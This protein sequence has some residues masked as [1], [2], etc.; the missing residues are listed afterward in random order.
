M[1][2][3]NEFLQEVG[4]IN[5]FGHS[6]KTP[7]EYHVIH[8]IFE[9]YD[10]WNEQMLITWEPHICSLENIAI[11][12]L[13]DEQI[14]FIF[15][16]ISSE[17]ADKIYEKWDNFIA[18]NHLENEIGLENEMMDMVKRDVSWACIERVLNIQGFFT[19]LLNIYRNGYF[20]CSWIGDYPNGQVVVL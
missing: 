8:S 16:T 1:T 10:D 15:T 2:M 4:S 11:E 20:P 14:D 13:G 12:K 7:N 19:T 6:K 3:L 5:W 17:I 18:E 9:A